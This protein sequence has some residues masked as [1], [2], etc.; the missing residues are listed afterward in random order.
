MNLNLKTIG[1]YILGVSILFSQTL[2]ED[3]V[4]FAAEK[5]WTI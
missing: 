2:W 1:S 3:S 4:I 5:R